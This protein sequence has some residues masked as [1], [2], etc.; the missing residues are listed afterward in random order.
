MRFVSDPRLGGMVPVI[1][2]AATLSNFERNVKLPSD[3]GIVPVRWLFAPKITDP[4][5][6]DIDPSSGG[7]VPVRLQHG[8]VSLP[9]KSKLSVWPVRRVCVPR[10]RSCSG[11]HRCNEH[12]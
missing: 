6:K 12:S 4:V 2:F 11:V 1:S 7:T 9:L 3:D 8:F 10:E 5:R